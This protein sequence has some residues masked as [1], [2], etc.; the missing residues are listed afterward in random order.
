MSSPQGPIRAQACR[1]V[2]RLSLG[3]C[4]LRSSVTSPVEATPKP[5]SNLEQS[6]LCLSPPHGLMPTHLPTHQHVSSAQRISLSPPSCRSIPLHP[7]VLCE[8]EEC[9]D[10][11]RITPTSHQP[12]ATPLGRSHWLVLSIPLVQRGCFW[13]GIP[14]LCSAGW[15]HHVPGDHSA[16]PSILSI[17]RAEVPGRC[18]PKAA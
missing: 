11:A 13:P 16:L 9:G 4:R 2:A 14:I 7:S 1:W 10:P 18:T 5:P 15:Y 3:T 17:F 8:G 6:L 12:S